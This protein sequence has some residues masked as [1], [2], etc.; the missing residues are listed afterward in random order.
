M[1]LRLCGPAFL[2]AVICAFP[3]F[4]TEAHLTSFG[5]AYPAAKNS[6][7]GTCTLCHLIAP[8][9]NSYGDAFKT[10]NHS[11]A[12]IEGADSDGDGFSN[13]AEI[14]ALTFPGIPSD[15]PSA[16]TT[17]SLTLTLDPAAAVTAGAQWRVGSGGAYQNSGATVTGLPAGSATIQ[18]KAVGGW[19]APADLTGTIVANRTAV[20]TGTYTRAL[21]SVPG[22][23]GQTLT[24]ASGMVS[25]A[26]LILGA[27]TQ[28]HS[29]TVPVGNVISQAPAAGTL[30]NPGA[31]VALVVSLGPAQVTVPNVVGQTHS[32][33]VTALTAAGL[34]VGVITQEY[35]AT[36]PAG[37]VLSQA[38]AAGLTVFSGSA[39]ALKVSKGPQPVIV[40]GV[41]GQTQA[42]A[43][44]AVTGAGL[45][46][47]AVTQRHDATVP[48]GMVI[49]QTPVAGAEA[50]PGSAVGLL[51][52]QGP[53]LVAVP[54][55][56]GQTQTAAATVIAS[57]GLVLG[58]VTQ[59][60]SATILAGRA[61]SQTPAANAQADAGTAVAL[62]LSQGPQ[63]VPVPDVTGL[64]QDAA[65]AAIT[66]AGLAVGQVNETP[67]D[68]VPAG[69]VISQIP[70][71]G[72]PAAPASLVNLTVSSGPQS[73][74]CACL[75]AK[76]GAFPPG[77]ITG[78]L[79]DLFMIGLALMA[80]QVK[81]RGK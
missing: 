6:R 59:E 42:A 30:V 17:G 43:T 47:G 4:A 71:A 2:L 76:K 46:V 13:L 60:Y 56:T 45:V 44:T 27:I 24:A 19:T 29:N 51:L 20:A 63:P 15:K 16:S 32:A 72:T 78:M 35:S 36:A 11:F 62:V 75:G 33:A 77:G 37:K 74:G 9:R 81:S 48:D 26:G 21:V 68:T 31:A 23:A 73:A 66:A 80:L 40:P 10:A 34:T 5:N 54:D 3:A 25:S 55:V 52:S 64:A 57:A 69:S 18:F 79:G 12:S 1:P 70:P 22:V 61:I 8:V 50:P 28:Q 14:N 39:V 7:I 65:A 58:T 53:G 49:S 67:S 41:V 38:P